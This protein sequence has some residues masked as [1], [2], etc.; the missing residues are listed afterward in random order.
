MAATSRSA[1]AVLMLKLW[2]HRFMKGVI[3]D[4]DEEMNEIT[5]TLI[6]ASEISKRFT[7]IESMLLQLLTY[8]AAPVV[9]AGIE[10]EEENYLL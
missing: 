3:D 10:T 6:V 8:V 1:I 9:E 5:S 4:E 2:F 7:A